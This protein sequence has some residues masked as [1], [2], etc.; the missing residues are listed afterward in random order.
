MLPELA[1]LRGVV[2]NPNHH[3]DVHE[4][5]IEVLARLLDVERD[6]DRYAGEAAGELRALLD[7]PLADDLSRGGALRLGAVLHDVGKPVTRQEHAGGMVSFV[8]HDREGA[9]IV[10]AACARLKASRVL[11]RHLEALT[12]HHLHLGFMARERPLSRR[13]E[14]E[15]LRLTAPVAADVTVLTIADRLSARGSGPTASAPMI[16]AHLEFARE[17]LPAARALAPR[18]ASPGADRRRSARRRDRDRAGAR[19][20]AADRRDR[21]RGLHRRGEDRRRRGRARQAPAIGCA[22]RMSDCIFCA[23]VAGDAPAEIV[24]SDEH[25]VAFMDINPATPGHTLVVPRIH[26]ADLIEIS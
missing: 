10:A 17:M 7:E 23:I 11:S 3:L 6:L 1:A 22:G 9:S 13:R 15:Y 4:H 14:Y 18:R 26:S 19:A 2:Q 20:R 25:T 8:G 24:D 16:E 5:T 21:G 12:L